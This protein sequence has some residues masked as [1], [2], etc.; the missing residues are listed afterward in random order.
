MGFFV[1]LFVRC[2][3]GFGFCGGLLFLVLVLKD[4]KGN[5]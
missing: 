4:I 3:V 2:L 1:V 5:L